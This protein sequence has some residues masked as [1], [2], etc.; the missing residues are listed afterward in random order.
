MAGHFPKQPASILLQKSRPRKTETGPMFLV[1]STLVGLSSCSSLSDQLC[2]L[3]SLGLRMPHSQYLP[4]PRRG[5]QCCLVSYTHLFPQMTPEWPSHIL[6]L[7]L[8]HCVASAFYACANMF[9]EST[10]NNHLNGNKISI[11][12]YLYFLAWKLDQCFAPFWKKCFQTE[13]LKTLL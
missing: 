4:R 6:L 7:S 3:C 5:L 9:S 1:R 11:V 12:S 13:A 10:T 8:W 2:G